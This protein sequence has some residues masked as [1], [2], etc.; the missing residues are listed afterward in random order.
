MSSNGV[1]IDIRKTTDTRLNYT[2]REMVVERPD[3]W[4]D[5]KAIPYNAVILWL[6]DHQAL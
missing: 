1:K 4:P 2:R 5:P 3:L 6:L